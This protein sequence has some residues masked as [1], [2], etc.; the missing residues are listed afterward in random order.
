MVTGTATRGIHNKTKR[1]KLRLR[2]S[3]QP[4]S[5]GSDINIFRLLPAFKLLGLALHPLVISAQLPVAG[6]PL[7]ETGGI[8]RLFT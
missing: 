5:T 3:C 1:Q 7:C 8:V 2:T 4:H 6:M